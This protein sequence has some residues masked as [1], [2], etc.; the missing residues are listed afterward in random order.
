SPEQVGID[1]EFGGPEPVATMADRFGDFDPKRDWSIE[2]V[3]DDAHN[4]PGCNLT[5]AE[6]HWIDAWDEFVKIM[7]PL[8]ADRPLPGFPIWADSWQD[9]TEM[10]RIDWY[11]ATIEVPDHVTMPRVD[12]DL[13]AWK[14]SHLRKNYD[15]FSRHFSAII[16]W[17]HQWKVYTDAFPA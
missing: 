14:Q 2:T 3:L 11:A 1:D 10:R 7:R 15:L 9:F 13:P 8:M 17:A 4:V 5:E 6:V 16:P 12:S